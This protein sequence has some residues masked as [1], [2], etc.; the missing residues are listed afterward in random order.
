MRVRLAHLWVD[1]LV[2]S[3]NFRFSIFNLPPPPPPPP[4]PSSFPATQPIAPVS[5]FPLQ[6]KEVSTYY[7]RHDILFTMFCIVKCTTICSTLCKILCTIFCIVLCTINP[8]DSHHHRIGYH[9]TTFLSA[10]KRAISCSN[11]KS[12]EFYSSFFGTFPLNSYF[13]LVTE[14]IREKACVLSSISDSF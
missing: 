7:A 11:V 14:Y 3:F 9:Q 4:P 12:I 8:H 2:I 5:H 1:F 6:R 13:F 10:S